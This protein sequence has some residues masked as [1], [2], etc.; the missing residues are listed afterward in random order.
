MVVFSVISR[1][2]VMVLIGVEWFSLQ[3]RGWI[4]GTL[5]GLGQVVA[6]PGS[7]GQYSVGGGV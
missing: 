6:I 2:G 4:A 1:Q 5:L 3:T 7:A